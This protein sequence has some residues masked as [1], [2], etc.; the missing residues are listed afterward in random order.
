MPKPQQA[1]PCT[2]PSEISLKRWERLGLSVYPVTRERE[3]IYIYIYIYTRIMRDAMSYVRRIDNHMEKII[4]HEV[5]T[6]GC[7]IVGVLQRYLLIS[8]S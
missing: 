1:T 2:S 8:W 6:Q 4:E 5:E 3:D 7:I